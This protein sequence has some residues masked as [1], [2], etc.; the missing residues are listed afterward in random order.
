LKQ[1]IG[2]DPAG[3]NVVVFAL[4]VLPEFQKR[5][6]A[7]QLMIRCVEEARASK[8]K[9]VLL[10]CKRHLITYYES[11]GFVYTGLSKSAHGSAEWHE[12]QL[13]L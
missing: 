1:L 10:M 7:R 8:K 9:N 2:H 4:A 3:K 5:G 6:I 13:K 12:M 11:M